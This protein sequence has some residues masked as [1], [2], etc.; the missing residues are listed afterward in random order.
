MDKCV[1][2]V[3]L[4][5]VT[6][7]I[8][9]QRLCLVTEVRGIYSSSYYT[10]CPQLPMWLKKR[11]D[12]NAT[13]RKKIFIFSIVRPPEIGCKH[14]G[15]DELERTF[16]KEV[17]DLK[18]A[19]QVF[20][21]FLLFLL[22]QNLTFIES[23]NKCLLHIRLKDQ[24]V[25]WYA[26]HKSLPI[27]AKD[28]KTVWSIETPSLPF[29]NGSL[30]I[31]VDQSLDKDTIGQYFCIEDRDD[32][33]LCAPNQD[34]AWPR[35]F[36]IENQN[37][38]FFQLKTLVSGLHNNRVRKANAHD[39]SGGQYHFELAEKTATTG[40]VW[41]AEIV[42]GCYGI[43]RP[44]TT[45]V[46]P[47][48]TMTTSTTTSATTTTIP[49][50]M[51]MTTTTTPSI[52]T[53]T[54]PKTTTPKTA[55][56]TETSR[57]ATTAYITTTEMIYCLN[58][59]PMSKDNFQCFK[60]DNVTEVQNII[61]E[62]ILEMDDN[63]DNGS[64]PIKNV[65]QPTVEHTKQIFKLAVKVEQVGILAAEQ[66]KENK[67]ISVKNEEIDMTIRKQHLPF[68]FP[69][70]S[71]SKIIVKGGPGLV[72][73]VGIVY[74]KLH[75]DISNK[76]ILHEDNDDDDNNNVEK[77]VFYKI[78][79]KVITSAVSNPSSVRS[80]KVILEHLKEIQVPDST[81]AF[82]NTT[83]NAWGID[84]CTKVDAESTLTFTVCECS[85]LTNFAI[86]MKFREFHV[87][88][89]HQ[90]ALNKLSLICSCV[91]I[92]FL[93]IGILL[94]TFLLCGGKRHTR[95]IIHINLMISL[96]IAQLIF[97]TGV[98]AV[99]NKAVCQS[100]A[101][102]LHYFYLASFCWMLVEGL[103]LYFAVIKVFS[104]GKIYLR[105]YFLFA[106][107]F[108]ALVVI[109]TGA[110]SHKWYGTEEYCWLSAEGY[111]V[112]AFIVPVLC[113]VMINMVILVLIINQIVV[114]A[115]SSGVVDDVKTG[116]RS[117]LILLPILGVTWVFG[118]LS[119]NT[120][121]IAFQYIFNIT[122]SLQG[123]MLTLF[124][125]FLNSEV[126]KALKRKT[127]IWSHT[128][129]FGKHLASMNVTRHSKYD[130]TLSTSGPLI[131]ATYTQRLT[132]FNC[133]ANSNTSEHP[134]RN[135]EYISNA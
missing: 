25:Y 133:N 11:R 41:K 49:T 109:V 114:L 58:D 38:V 56:L 44:Q 7:S 84:G 116:L 131:H 8:S 105:W 83:R 48:T 91:S 123:F 90:N 6:K 77:N 111:S 112:W 61:E 132:D 9:R 33:H 118:I 81:C 130:T 129:S 67:T 106:W 126:R 79:S 85:H 63:H 4:R 39:N 75:E 26:Y 53:T 36:K 15:T 37:G 51:A 134:E 14:E 93:F 87:T 113:V 78:N 32:V 29:V 95:H 70:N 104:D 19:F 24:P 121:T 80:V 45:T 30:S 97:V 103:Y 68:S 115:N 52:T 92:C 5:K 2:E 16:R 54:T 59:Q 99:E 18:Q 46:S 72:G 71:S 17:D 88:E 100:V 27:L 22:L 21:V 107:G 31:K 96:F 94:L 124:H 127:E 69:K 13:L 20:R 28:Y 120:E 3:K 102:L 117:S 74:E 23:R 65:R 135:V 73:V 122:N 1:D 66:L 50:T 98:G 101:Y 34:S 62:K 43:F 128:T 12:F 76:I 55:K 35:S 108:P 125:C 10:P 57:K 89:V 119:F 82:W 64:T 42:E 86:L 60:P 47:P 110:T 40:L